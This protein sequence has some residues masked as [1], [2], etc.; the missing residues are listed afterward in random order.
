MGKVMLKFVIIRHG[1]NP[2]FGLKQVYSYINIV[3]VFI[4]EALIAEV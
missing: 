1:V 2:N 4:T 3:I